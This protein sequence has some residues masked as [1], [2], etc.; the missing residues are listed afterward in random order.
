MS[1]LSKIIVKIYDIKEFDEEMLERSIK[2][3]GGEEEL[4]ELRELDENK[5]IEE[6]E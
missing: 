1:S 4:I 5:R 2:V 6:K 3:I